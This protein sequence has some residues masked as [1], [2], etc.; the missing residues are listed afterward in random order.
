MAWMYLLLA[1]LL[2]IGFTTSMRYTEGFT[3]LW[4]TAL[5]VAFIAAS[6]YFMNKAAETIP[7]GTVYAVWAGIGAAGTVLLGILYF[8]ESADLPRLS[9]LALLIAS[10]MGLK[11]VTPH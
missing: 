10:I 9:F 1:G 11:F 7:L 3:R 4:P 5:F 2:E 8:N 6:L